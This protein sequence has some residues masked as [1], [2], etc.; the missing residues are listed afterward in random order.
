MPQTPS[1]HITPESNYTGEQLSAMLKGEWQAIWDDFA[2]KMM[3]RNGSD[4][5]YAGQRLAQNPLLREAIKEIRDEYF[6][7]LVKKL[8]LVRQMQ[9]ADP[10]LVDQQGDLLQQL[11]DM[12]AALVFLNAASL[13]RLQKRL[14]GFDGEKAKT[15]LGN[16]DQTAIHEDLDGLPSR[17]AAAVIGSVI[18]RA[19][20]AFDHVSHKMGYPRMEVPNDFGKQALLG[21]ARTT[22]RLMPAPPG[23][24]RGKGD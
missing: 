13:Q 22:G 3:E 10:D 14:Y 20:D 16:A 12:D 23:F 17:T 9:E 5:A 11:G 15:I 4:P 6:D 8:P 7:L 24:G 1:T 21:A 18:G 2:Q 19:I